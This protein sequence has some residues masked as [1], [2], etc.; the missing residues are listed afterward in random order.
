MKQLFCILT[1]LI[2]LT[3][4]AQ[5]V[6]VVLSGGGAKGAAHV[7]FLKA[8]EAN[9]I[10]I[11]YIAG[12][13]MGAVV[14]GLYAAGYSPYE[15]EYIFTSEEFI[16]ASKGELNNSDLFFFNE[17]EKDASWINFKLSRK[18]KIIESLPTNF[19]NPAALDFKTM[20]LF[21]GPEAAANYNFDSLFV[22]FRCVAADIAE[23]KR[24]YF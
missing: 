15:I 4:N 8:L 3:C 6:G 7:G 11:D 1:C 12:T 20:T 22:P 9:N 14:A 2:I 16:K 23:K 13:S 10:P 18:N 17:K 24:S 5:K 19:I 21:A